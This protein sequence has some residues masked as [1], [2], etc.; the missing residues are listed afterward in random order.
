MKLES[1]EY[2]IRIKKDETYAVGSAD[3]IHYDVILNP[4]NKRH[5]DYYSV[6]AVKIDKFY[7]KTKIALIGDYYSYD[8]DCAF[9]ENNTLTIMQNNTFT[10]I[11]L[12]DYSI[13]FHKSFDGYGM[14]FAIYKF[15]D[16]YVVYG[17]LSVVKLNKDYEK[18]WEFSGKDIFITQNGKEPFELCNDRI[19][20]Y[21]WLGNYY[22]LDRNG[23]LLIFKEQT[24]LL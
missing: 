4:E 24:E 15:N 3:N 16:G 23:N 19:K 8:T 13:I 12:D 21:D 11:N 10:Q 7:E 22:E 5:N 6:L 18:E 2:K 1:S 17:E 20:L 9:L 14:F